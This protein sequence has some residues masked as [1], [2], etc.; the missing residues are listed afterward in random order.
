MTLVVYRCRMIRQHEIGLKYRTIKHI[1]PQKQKCGSADSGLVNFDSVSLED[2]Y[3][4]LL[5]LGYGMCV[6]ALVFLF[7]RVFK[8]RSTKRKRTVN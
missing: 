6:S 8:V 2:I 1:M 3:P 4:A 5:F 7:E